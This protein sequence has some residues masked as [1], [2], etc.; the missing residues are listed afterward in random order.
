MKPYY[1]YGKP[2]RV[3][4]TVWVRLR[5]GLTSLV[6]TDVKYGVHAFSETEPWLAIKGSSSGIILQ[7]PAGLVG[8]RFYTDPTQEQREREL[9]LLLKHTL[10]RGR[11]SLFTRA[12]SA[13]T[14]EEVMQ[15]WTSALKGYQA[16]DSPYR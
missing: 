3:G 7:G 6:V 14:Q 15:V 4:D 9:G 10:D 16:I 1:V 12:L 13:T 8:Q 5:S 11:E 2:V